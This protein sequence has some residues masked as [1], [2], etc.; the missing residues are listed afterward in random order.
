LCR[1]KKQPQQAAAIL[2]GIE[3]MRLARVFNGLIAQ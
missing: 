1:I 3:A 2:K